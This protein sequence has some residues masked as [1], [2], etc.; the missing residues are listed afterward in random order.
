M[1][2]C[3]PSP[4]AVGRLLSLA[5]GPQFVEYQAIKPRRITGNSSGLQQGLPQVEAGVL[6]K[7]FLVSQRPCLRTARSLAPF[8]VL[9]GRFLGNHSRLV[10]NCIRRQCPTIGNHQTYI[11]TGSESKHL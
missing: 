1:L 4:Q 11:E 6:G 2:T 8:R 3:G 9:L 7:S 10:N 5:A